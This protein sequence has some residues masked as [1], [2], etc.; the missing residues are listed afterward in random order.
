MSRVEGTRW[1][2]DRRE[3]RMS[4]YAP[5]ASV[6]RR[7]AASGLRSGPVGRSWQCQLD[8]SNVESIKDNPSSVKYQRFNRQVFW[9]SSIRL[10][11][12]YRTSTT[13]FTQIFAA[14]QP[15]QQLGWYRCWKAS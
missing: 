3:L 6:E 8:V 1:S 14:F 2:I 10:H 11:S 7:R 5:G 12:W 15:R 4:K 9:F 13:S